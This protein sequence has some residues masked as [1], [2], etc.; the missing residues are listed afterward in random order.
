MVT[1]LAV[2]A[3]L[4]VLTVLPVQAESPL[5]TIKA[6]KSLPINGVRMI[7]T[8]QGVFFASDNGRFVW[9]GPLYDMWSARQVETLADVEAVA[10]RV[11]LK[12]LGVDFSQLA[13]FSLGQG[14]TE[15]VLF[16]SPSCPHCQSIM[17]Q[18]ERLGK[19][20]RFT[21]VLLPLGNRDVDL[22][23]RLVCLADKDKALQALLSR[24]YEGLP[25]GECPLTPLQKNLVTARVLGITSVPYLIR[26]DGLIKVG[27]VADLAGWLKGGK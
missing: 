11:D 21:V 18:A 15:E 4:A 9:K 2:A 5:G 8:E 10:G 26:H 16:I 25:P 23:R 20:Y 13:T 12:R 3:I 1:R 6:V 24:K 19:D 14:G 27:E 17:T 22:A 7:E